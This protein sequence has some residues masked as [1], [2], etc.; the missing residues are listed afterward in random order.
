MLW[1]NH[2]I[3]SSLD[4]LAFRQPDGILLDDLLDDGLWHAGVGGVEAP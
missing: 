3:V 4:S 2:D 1:A